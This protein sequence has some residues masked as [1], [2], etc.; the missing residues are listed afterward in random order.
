[1]S[2]QAHLARFIRLFE[3]LSREDVPKLRE[4]YTGDAYF[5]DPFNEV[6]GHAAIT[7]I[8]EHMFKQVE[9]P[10]FTVTGSILQDDEAFIVWDFRFHTKGNG[11]AEQCI[12]GSSHLRFTADHKVYYHR[13]YWD[14]AEE[15]YEK[16][17][18]LGSLM[19]FL[20][21]RVGS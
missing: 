6:R 11:H 21:R 12:R 3:S 8:F 4:F 2:H 7:G 13:D 9:D 19:R 16:I 15:L 1:M 18:V 20:K 17:P 5:K 10:R 14:A